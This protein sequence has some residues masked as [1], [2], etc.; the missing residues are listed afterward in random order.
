MTG[1]RIGRAMLAGTLGGAVG[2]PLGGLG[3]AVGALIGGGAGMAIGSS[4]AFTGFLDHIK[5]VTQAL[6]R[7][8]ERVNETNRRFERYNGTIATAMM[9]LD[10]SRLHREI[11][12]GK[13]VAP[14]A[15]MLAR[16]VNRFEQA[17]QP[18]L[19]FSNNAMNLVGSG[20]ANVGTLLSK[21][22][23]TLLKISGWDKYLEEMIH[24]LAG[25][26]P[27]DN[28][29]MQGAAAALLG[30][31]VAN[32]GV[33]QV[34]QKGRHA[35]GWFGG[36]AAAAGAGWL[37]A[38]PVGGFV[39]PI[40]FD[41]AHEKA[42]QFGNAAGRFIGDKWFGNPEPWHGPPMPPAENVPNPVGK[43][44]QQNVEM[45]AQPALPPMF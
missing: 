21:M 10:V 8:A 5:S 39:A 30:V 43:Q 35:P 28:L 23:S 20:L 2:G 45:G 26:K 36:R 22:A 19:E 34:P 13:K 38:G 25:K 16:S 18:L 9:Q 7:M 31:G 12:M 1:N 44:Q 15:A 11:E 32:G 4:L 24:E 27:N 29:P 40:V 33:Q 17:S 41:F 6:G 42:G 37:A 3:G 14:G